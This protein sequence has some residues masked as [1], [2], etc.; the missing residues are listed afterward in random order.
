MFLEYLVSQ[1]LVTRTRRAFDEALRSL[2]I[3][4]HKRIWPLYLKVGARNH[5]GPRSRVHA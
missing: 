4:Q 1:C 2:P 5:E 3:T